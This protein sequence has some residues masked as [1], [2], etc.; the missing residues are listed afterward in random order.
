MNTARQKQSRSK[1][2]KRHAPLK[3]RRITGNAGHF[4][5]GNQGGT[6]TQ[7]KKGQTGNRYGRPRTAEFSK[8]VR[9]FLRERDLKRKDGKR[10]GISANH[11]HNS[12]LR[13]QNHR[14]KTP[15]AG[16]WCK[17]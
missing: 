13:V 17:A 1:E 15:G 16:G 9:L 8:E 14:G 10:M 4:K 6:S 5:K 2:P 3:N 11:P 7:F 12:I